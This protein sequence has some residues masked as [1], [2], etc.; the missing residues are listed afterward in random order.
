[1]FGLFA[2]ASYVVSLFSLVGELGLGAA[3]IRS[4][5][6]ITSHELNALFSFQ[7]ALSSAIAT[8]VFLL[9]PLFSSLYSEPGV[10]WVVRALAFTFV[11]TS[12]RSVPV[13]L[14]EREL[15]YGPVA[16][17]DLAGQTG[18]WVVA[19]TAAFAGFGVWSLV[20]AVLASGLLSTITLYSRTH[21]RPALQLDWRPLRQSMR[22]GA[23]YQAQSVVHFFKD[24]MIP[25]LGGLLYGGTAVGY[26]TWAQQLASVPLQFTHLVSRVSYPA[27]SHLQDDRE[28]FAGMVE[29]T[30][31]WTARLTLPA[32]AVLAGLAPQIVLYVFGDKWL[33]ALPTLYLLIIN[34]VFGIATGVFVPAL[35]SVGRA[36]EALRIAG[37]WGIL[38][39]S[40]A[41]ALYVAGAGFEA[42]GAA[43]AVGTVVA[44]VSLTLALR[45]VGGLALLKGVWAPAASGLVIA[46]ALYLAA[47]LLV[48][49]LI[50]LVMLSVVG[51]L[52]CLTLNLW[53]DRRIAW[54]ALSR[55]MRRKRTAGA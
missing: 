32:F 42:L 51:G 54:A 18:Y 38:T 13:V 52:V 14:A 55:A 35:Y 9:A 44:V 30:L 16:I 45:D 19:A 29:T 48:N 22:F 49:N 5:K 33:P 41:L 39:W 3:F 43:Y 10:E 24:T 4:R 17:S 8:I 15:S 27:L 50:T 26:A 40:V 46:G 12:L 31:K 25:A 34:M 53:T 21:W 28:Q 2:I 7:L 37:A 23:L 6:E 36:S 47:P 20:L 11:L 1:M